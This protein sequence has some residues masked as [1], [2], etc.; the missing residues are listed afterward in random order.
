MWLNALNA[1]LSG[2]PETATRK[3]FFFTKTSWKKNKIYIRDSGFFF[4]KLLGDKL[5][6]VLRFQ[7][8]FI[9]SWLISTCLVIND[10][11]I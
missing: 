6:H 11:N 8:V 4:E 3:V 2:P 5:E 10:I 9:N 7:V 1:K